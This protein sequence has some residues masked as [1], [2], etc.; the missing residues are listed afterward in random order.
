MAARFGNGQ[1]G[2]PW[3]CS[4][5]PFR[6][7]ALQCGFTAGVRA[8]AGAAPQTRGSLPLSQRSARVQARGLGKSADLF[9]KLSFQGPTAYVLSGGSWVW[10]GIARKGVSP[11]GRGG[12]TAGKEP[13]ACA[14]RSSPG[15]RGGCRKGAAQR[16]HLCPV[17][18][19]VVFDG[20]KGWTRIL[21]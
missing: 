14:L 11:G 17:L 16:G 2:W 9:L 7:A 10:S 5:R 8:G 18:P 15:Q 12:V 1:T 21:S 4:W 6:P 20:R 19:D 13:S 3:G